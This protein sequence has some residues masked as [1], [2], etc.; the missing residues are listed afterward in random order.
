[1]NIKAMKQALD[2]FETWQKTCIDN[3]VPIYEIFRYIALIRIMRQAVADAEQAQPVAWLYDF[4]ID[5]EV[6][7]NWITQDFKDIEN[8]NGFNVRKLYATQQQSIPLAEQ[9]IFELADKHLYGGKNYGV[10]SFARAIEKAHR[11]I[12]DDK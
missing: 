8:S 7:E 9:I 5:G 1:M 10:F 2:E 4:I 11:I 3:G 6:V 12:E